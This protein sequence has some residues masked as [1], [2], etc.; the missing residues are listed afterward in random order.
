MRSG[1][2]RK[3]AWFATLAV[4]LTASSWSACTSKGPRTSA[5]GDASPSSWAYPIQLGD[6]RTKAHEFLGNA[7]RTTDVL[8][9]YPMSGVTLWFDPEGRL[10]KLNFHGTAGS[11][12]SGANSMVGDNWIPSDRSPVFGLTA[13]ANES[14]FARV[15]GA[16]IS[17]NE[18]GSANRLEVRRVWR[19]D[20]Y[21]IDALFLGAD[22][23][24]DRKAFSRGA[25]LWFEVSRRL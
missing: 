3:H 2:I 22:R 25:L 18:A 5:S 16:P 23:T 1:F 19:K 11:L 4:L 24:E 10:T 20:G 21:L 8:E 7:T 17:E 6:S 15:L 14:D 9:E 13:S 12:Y